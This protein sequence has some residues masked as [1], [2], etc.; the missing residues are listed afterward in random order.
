[1]PAEILQAVRI[2]RMTALQKPQGGIRG[3]VVGDFICRAAHVTLPICTIHRIWMRVCRPHRSS[4]DRS[5]PHHHLVGGIG[6]FDLISREAMLQGLMEVDGRDAALPFVRQFY[7]SPSMCWRT[8]DMGVTHEMWQDEGG[9]QCD[10]FM[11][12]LH[13][14]SQHRALVHV[15]RL[16]AFLDVYVSNKPD[17][18]EVHQSLDREMWERGSDSIKARRN[19]GTEAEWPQ[20]DGKG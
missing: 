7:G 11:P 10:P 5:R 4:G 3:I 20:R 9:E 1:M 19:C 17:R 14:C 18:T 16:S 13:A 15:M 12:A 8:D 2:G 6:A